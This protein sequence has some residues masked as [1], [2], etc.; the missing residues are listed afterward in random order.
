MERFARVNA[1]AAQDP[2]Y[3]Q[4]QQQLARLDLPFLA[5]LEKLEPRERE[6]ILD[7]VRLLGTAA[8]RLTEL[9]CENME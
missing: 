1:L 3:R 6:T 2:E 9:A 4:L 5:A 7:Y 8:L